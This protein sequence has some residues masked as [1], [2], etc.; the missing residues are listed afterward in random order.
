MIIRGLAVGN[1]CFVV[2]N[3]K[4]ARTYTIDAHLLRCQAG[5]PFEC[6]GTAIAI[7]DSSH[8]TD[9]ALFI[10]EGSVVRVVNFSGTQKGV[11]NFSEGEGH[12][13]LLDLNGQYLG[14][15]TSKDVIKFFDVHSPTKP[16]ALGSAGKFEP[17]ETLVNSGKT[18]NDKPKE[19]TSK[20]KVRT[21][22]SSVN[23]IHTPIHID[24]YT[25][26]HLYTSTHIHLY[27][28]TP[29]HIYTYTH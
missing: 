8:I 26:I 16:K 25:H 13:E 18:D 21:Y 20:N 15:F 4:K 1:G 11:I 12:P 3:G 24:T 9:E 19:S 28:Y 2:W 10:A 7:A 5:E 6:S 27:T 22:K 23:C 29:K 14:V 17:P